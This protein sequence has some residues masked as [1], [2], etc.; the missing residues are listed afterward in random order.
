MPSSERLAEAALRK[1]GTQP[2]VFQ[3][4]AN[5]YRNKRLNGAGILDRSGPTFTTEWLELTHLVAAAETLAE[6]NER[7]AAVQAFA[8]EWRLDLGARKELRK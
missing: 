1:D 7:L 3:V 5:I 4:A 8:H 6:L 2:D